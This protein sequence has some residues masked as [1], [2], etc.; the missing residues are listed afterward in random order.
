MDSDVDGARYR[1]KS[2]SLIDAVRHRFCKVGEEHDVL[3][4]GQKCVLRR[5]GGNGRTIALAS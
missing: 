3:S 2:D 4:S 1:F 5:C